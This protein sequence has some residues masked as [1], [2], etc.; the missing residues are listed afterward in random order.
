VPKGGAVRELKRPRAARLPA[1]LAP[2]LAT[3]VDAAPEGDDWLHEIKFDGYRLLCHLDHGRVRLES[4]GGHDW[5]ERFPSAAAAL[6]ALPARTALLDGEAIVR[7]EHGVSRFQALQ[8]AL[9]RG[10]RAAGVELALFDC[11]HLDGR[12]LA[13]ARLVGRKELLEGLLEELPA[14]SPLLY[15]AHQLGRGPEFFAASCESGLEGI[16]SKRADAPYRSGR[17]RDWLKVKCS[18]RQELVIAGWTEPRG[19]RVGLGALLL[20]AHDAQGKLRYCGKVGTGFASAT[21]EKLRARLERIGRDRSPLADPPRMRAVHWVAPRLV[22]EVAFTEWTRDGRA[23]HPVF[24][25][26]RED[27]AAAEVSFERPAAG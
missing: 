11:V 22:A 8:A 24:L 17:S 7:D 27:K 21:L 6:A 13:G 26:L 10:A 5:S 20:G 25:G 19:S 3:L 2:Q 1:R 18:Q 4:R 14:G 23:R 12:N 16:L 15:S 9:G